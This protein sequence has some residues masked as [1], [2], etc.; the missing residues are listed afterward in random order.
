MVQAT[1]NRPVR[2]AVVNNDTTF[3]ALMRDLL[4]QE[5][6]DMSICKETRS[7]YECVKAQRLHLVILDIRM[8]NEEM[9]WQILDL[10]KLDP[11]TSRIPVIVCS[12]TVSALR[13]R[14]DVLRRHGTGVLEKPFD[15]NDL[16][17]L[18]LIE[19][20]LGQAQLP[21]P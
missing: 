8:G 7:A 4:E 2:I 13:E 11:T 10:L 19:D 3:L 16:F 14:A 18:I 12:A 20:V 15:L 17:G 6:Y 9:G 1:R 5:G 21:Q